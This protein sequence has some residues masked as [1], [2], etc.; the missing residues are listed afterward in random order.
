VH[1]DGSHAQV[2]LTQCRPLP[3]DPVAQ[4]PPHPSL[5][6][7][8]FPV[9]L[10]TQTHE[11]WVQLQLFGQ[12]AQARPPVPHALVLV[13]GSQPPPLQH[14]PAHDVASHRHAPATHRSP[15]AQLPFMQ[16]EVQ[17]SL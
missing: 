15:A 13:P 12:T 5:A 8:A 1:D 17:P 4:V 16:I 7:H 9:Q 14:P 3:Q 6:P 10:G 2:P 11:P